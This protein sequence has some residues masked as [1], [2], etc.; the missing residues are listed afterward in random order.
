MKKISFELVNGYARGWHEVPE[1]QPALF[2]NTWEFNDIPD[3]KTLPDGTKAVLTAKEQLRHFNDNYLDYTLNNGGLSYDA[4]H[5]GFA[6]QAARQQAQVQIQALKQRLTAMDY[7]TSKYADGEFTQTEWA[8]VVA[9]RR[10]LRAQIR[11]LGG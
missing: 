10:T 1:Q 7:K 3:G 9:E 11:Q 6:A 8:A 4:Q 2:P 5:G